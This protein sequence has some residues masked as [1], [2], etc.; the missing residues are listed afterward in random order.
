MK[1]K[2]RYWNDNTQVYTLPWIVRNNKYVYR[3][4]INTRYGTVAKFQNWD[5]AEVTG[6]LENTTVWSDEQWE[7]K[8][9]LEVARRSIHV[10]DDEIRALHT[11]QNVIGNARTVT[12]RSED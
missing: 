5:D 11:R 9:N 6:R 3:Y 10:G 7:M 12:M 1:G 2:Y 4:C 8:R